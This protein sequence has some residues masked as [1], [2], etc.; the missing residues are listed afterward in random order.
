MKP[1]SG[2]ALFDSAATMARSL[3]CFLHGKPFRSLGEPWIM[4]RIAPLLNLLP[5]PARRGVFALS[6]LT[7]AVTPADAGNVKSDQAAKWFTSLY[8]KRR[9]PVIAIGSSN[10]AL[11]HLCAAV[12]APW[13]PQTFLTPV[14]HSGV[15]PDDPQH[16]FDAGLPVIERLLSANPDVAVHYMHDSNQDRLVLRH[17]GLFRQ[18]FIKLSKA[19]RQFIDMHLEPGGTLLI[20][21]CDLQWP[22]RLIGDRAVFQF[23][24]VG[25]ASLEEYYHGGPRVAAYLQAFGDSR[26]KWTPPVADEM[27]MESE[28]GFEPRLNSDL[29]QTAHNAKAQIRRLSFNQPEDLSAFVADFY[30]DWLTK[31]GRPADRL[32]AESFMLLDPYLALRTGSVP[33][34]LVFNAKPSAEVLHHFLDE[35]PGFREIFI[36][37]FSNGVEAIGQATMDDW[38]SVLDRAIKR[39]DL[40]GVDRDKFPADLAAIVRYSKAMERLETVP[41]PPAR[42]AFRAVDEFALRWA[43]ATVRLTA[44]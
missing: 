15:D 30:R 6:S 13:L 33:F 22:V 5:A 17:M 43:G 16:G 21:D 26:Q 12:G 23:G 11:M 24:G 18:K 7:Y 40:L 39:G 38:Q 10:G 2:I 9:Y 14:R 20:V 3:A 1:P 37:L 31:T 19:Y 41:A 4:R 44:H 25:G 35:R 42:V 28:W 36:S 8:P 32:L 29:Y 34:W 27:T